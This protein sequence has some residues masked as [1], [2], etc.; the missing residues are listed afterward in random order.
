MGEVNILLPPRMGVHQIHFPREQDLKTGVSC[1]S[2][3]Y[4][5]ESATFPYKPVPL[6][7]NIKTKM[8]L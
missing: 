6:K 1:V 4:T 2:S 8:D 7:A 3:E 5:N